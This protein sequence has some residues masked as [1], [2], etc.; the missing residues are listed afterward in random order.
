MKIFSWA[1]NE[2]VSDTIGVVKVG[3]YFIFHR[4]FFEYYVWQ[5]T[6]GLANQSS[7]TLTTPNAY[8]QKIII[9]LSF[10]HSYTNE[11]FYIQKNPFNA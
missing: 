6:S 10:L 4:F 5:K 11:P 2:S 1:T 3:R 8:N 7:P 9:K